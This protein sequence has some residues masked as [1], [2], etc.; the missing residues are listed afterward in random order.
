MSEKNSHRRF[1]RIS[2]LALLGA[3]ALLVYFWWPEPQIT[4]RTASARRGEVEQVV[5]SV[6]A[7]EIRPLRRATLRAATIG[8]VQKLHFQ[9]GQWV[10][11]GDLLVELENSGL[12]A[13]LRLAQANLL[14]GDSA[15]RSANLRLQLARQSLE[16]NRALA[17][18]GALAAQA[19][20]R[21]QSE[22]DMAA[23]A[24]AAAEANLVQL[25]AAVEVARTALD[26]SYLRAPFA[27][28]ITELYTDLG[29]TL[30]AGAPVLELVDSSVLTVR[31][32]IDEADATLVR[33][34]QAARVLADAFGDRPL[35][36]RV[37]RI[38]P[39]VV[40]DVRQNRHL[41]VEVTLEGASFD[42]LRAGMSADLE[43]VV[44][45]E[46]NAL[47]VPSGAVIHRGQLEQLY[48]IEGGRAR[49]RTVR[50][51]L[52]SFERTQILDGLREGEAVIVD[53]S[54]KYLR[55]GVPV[56]GENDEQPAG[57]AA[58]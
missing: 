38:W 36:G 43:I 45:R 28:Q 56:Q 52:K 42:G 8:R 3:A 35:A 27:G 12:Q 1:K 33:E 55:E 23:E 25:R 44:A 21:T 26:D 46:Q 32:P 54:N 15:L 10:K 37:S 5:S 50:T 2:T 39:V 7:G 19:L 34:G 18:K 58:R 22:F 47:Y 11:E 17:E 20:E 30:M 31:A 4:L 16:R 9:E 57:P 51:G 53:L 48:V 49:L 13:R 41:Q 24:V 40:K 29:E 14:A 6:Q